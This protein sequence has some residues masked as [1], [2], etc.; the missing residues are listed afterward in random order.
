MT[1]GFTLHNSPSMYL[2]RAMTIALIMG[3]MLALVNIDVEARRGGGGGG[4]RAPRANIG[5]GGGRDF[6][7]SDINVNR[8]DVNVSHRDVN[9]NRN[10]DVDVDRHWGYPV[11]AGAV[12]VGTAVAVGAIVSSLPPNCTTFVAE[13]ITYQNCGGTYYVPR[14]DG[15]NVVYE[16]VSPPSGWNQ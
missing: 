1:E 6:N 3:P 12:A 15:P 9:I 8:R 7:R 10:V 11:G 2:K 14:Y 13:G 5:G 16:A 4:V